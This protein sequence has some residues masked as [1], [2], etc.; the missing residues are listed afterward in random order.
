MINFFEHA[1]LIDGHLTRDRIIIDVELVT[2]NGCQRE[3]ILEGTRRDEEP[4]P[5]EVM[6]KTT[7]KTMFALVLVCYSLS[8]HAE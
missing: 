7:G 6:N 5:L 8:N 2:E 1:I 4:E 3:T